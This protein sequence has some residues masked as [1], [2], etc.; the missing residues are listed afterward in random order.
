MTSWFN[1]Q[2]LSYSGVS[3]IAPL[4]ELADVDMDE[5][6]PP[7]APHTDTIARG[8]SVAPVNKRRSPP[9]ATRSRRLRHPVTLSD[10]KPDDAPPDDK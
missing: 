3:Y 6:V 7:P 5:T 1:D 2:S 9:R 4:G 10:P 8:P